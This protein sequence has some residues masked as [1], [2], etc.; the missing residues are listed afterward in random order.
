MATVK[1]QNKISNK[2]K[3]LSEEKTTVQTGLESLA[4]LDKENAFSPNCRAELRDELE[5]QVEQFL[6][7]G[8][9]IKKIEPNVMADPPKKPTSNY[10]SRP[11]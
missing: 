7:Q 5:R 4:K 10:G 3:L 1:D 2:E 6:Q 8:G 9:E 11:I